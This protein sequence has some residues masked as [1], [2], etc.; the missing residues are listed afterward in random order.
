MNTDP[1][2]DI[3]NV[4]FWAGRIAAFI[5]L[6]EHYGMTVEIAG[7]ELVVSRQVSDV[8][9][10]QT[11]VQWRAAPPTAAPVAAPPTGQT[12]DVLVAEA[13][14]A[15]HEV[16]VTLPAWEADRVRALIAELEAAVARSATEFSLRG[17][18]AIRAAAFREAV[19]EMKRDA[20]G[21][22][23]RLLRM[24]DEAE[25]GCD[26]DSQVID[27]EG[28]QYWACLKCGMNLGRVEVLAAETPG[29]ET[30]GEAH[31]PTSTWKVE[32]P[33]RD[34]DTWASWGATYDERDWARERYESAIGNAPARPFRLVRATATYTVEAEH[35][36]DTVPAADVQFGTDGCTCILFTRQD[37]TPRYCGP[38]DT[39]D[40]ISGWERG[41]DCPHHA[42]AVVA[43]PGKENDRG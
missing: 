1:Q 14:R 34:S 36:P 31:P 7:G 18:A 8:F 15:V 28:A 37:G 23:P 39:V 40:M 5:K 9:V 13:R 17:T 12:A 11:E 33:R 24:A 41:G 43:E 16:L 38:T 2:T 30:Q 10:A 26:H 25:S 19:A 32:S 29:P 27:H 21:V 22:I 6:A 35:T 4:D 3:V 42:P 20:L